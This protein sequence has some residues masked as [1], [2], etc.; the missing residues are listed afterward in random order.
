MGKEVFISVRVFL[1]VLVT[2]SAAGVPSN[3]QIRK[4]FGIAARPALLALKLEVERG[5]GHAIIE[6]ISDSSEFAYGSFTIDANGVPTIT[7]AKDDL[8]EAN[9]A[10]ELMHLKLA[11]QGHPRIDWRT[12]DS[13]FLTMEMAK[14]LAGLLATI[15]DPIEHFIFRPSITAMG[16]AADPEDIEAVARYVHKRHLKEDQ[17]FG[18]LR[19]FGLTLSVRDSALRQQLLASYN[20]DGLEAE[21]LTGRRMA[22]QVQGANPKTPKEATDC[23]IACLNIY[24]AGKRSATLLS[25]SSEKLGNITRAVATIG[26]TF[27]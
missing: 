6:R 27:Y 4:P 23:L 14:E 24:W 19:F 18:I 9:L 17:Q 8:T 11:L 10:H 3:R 20:R 26:V 21:T 1:I 15:R 12:R 25:W 5:F 7:L 16:I 13:R 2:F 22:L